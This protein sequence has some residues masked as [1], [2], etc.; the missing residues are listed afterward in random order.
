MAQMHAEKKTI[1]FYGIPAYGHIHSNL[2]FACRLSGLG[3][4][5]IYY[6]LEP[7]REEIEV[8]GCEFRDYP[9]DQKAV[10]LSDGKKLL[11][12]YRILLG[13]T[14]DMLPILLSQAREVMPCCII[15]DS[16]ALW[17]RVT[18][19]LLHVDSFSFYSIA[20]IDRISGNAFLAYA[21]GFS[22]DF[23]RYAAELPQVIHIRRQLRKEYGIRNM[24]MLP[25]LMNRGDHN[26]MGYSRIFQP[27]GASFG[28]DYTFLGPLSVHRAPGKANDFICP[29]GTVIYISL[30]TVFNQ[31]ERLLGEV[32]RQL[33]RGDGRHC[34]VVMV[35][36]AERAGG[37]TRDMIAEL[38]H[39]QNFTIRPFVNQGEIMRKADLFITAGGMNSIHEALYYSV[40]CLMCP[41][42]GEQRLNALRFEKL[43]FG[44]IL[45]DP[46]SL[47]QEIKKAMELKWTWNNDIR[48]QTLQVHM[49][50]TLELFRKF[51]T[52]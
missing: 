51:L 52:T 13:Y 49:E 20:A 6:A 48:R 7:F 23:L 9:L 27:G 16:L 3:F 25:A 35:W 47:Y 50:E 10:D 43:G 38:K 39:L 1:I 40:P 31:D 18:G 4:R 14:R 45:K 34:H 36:D 2:Y 29:E 28:A 12:L 33:G 37:R 8:N 46:G 32:L 21:S 17:G 15:F 5:V 11:R 30:G 24:G 41:Q 19:G 44:R 26:L 42:Q 22:A